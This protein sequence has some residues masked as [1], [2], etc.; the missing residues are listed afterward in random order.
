VRGLHLDFI[1]R[2]GLEVELNRSSLPGVPR[3]APSVIPSSPTS[4][5]TQMGT[6][7]VSHLPGDLWHPGVVVMGVDL[8]Q[9][10][11]VNAARDRPG[12]RA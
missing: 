2:G 10:A 1:E 7:R 9:V 11:L 12:W 4:T 3:N 5:T 8:G 6:S